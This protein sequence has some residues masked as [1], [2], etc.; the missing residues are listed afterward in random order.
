MPG[1]SGNSYR[2]GGMQALDYA[3]KEGARH[4]TTESR[5]HGRD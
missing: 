3:I 1:T 4:R 5:N 2:R